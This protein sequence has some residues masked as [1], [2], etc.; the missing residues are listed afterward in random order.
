[1]V[2]DSVLCVFS[3]LCARYWFFGSLVIRWLVTS[4]T[5][6][7][8]LWAVCCQCRSVFSHSVLVVQVIREM[9]RVWK[10]SRDGQRFRAAAQPAITYNCLN[11]V[12]RNYQPLLPGP[13]RHQRYTPRYPPWNRPVLLQ[14]PSLYPSRSMIT[15]V[16]RV[17]RGVLKIRYVLLGGAVGGGVSMQRVS[18]ESFV[19]FV[20]ACQWVLGSWSS[21]GG[22]LVL[23]IDLEVR[24]Y[25]G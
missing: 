15:L 18:L 14:N 6:W 13:H 21:S 20:L 10:H 25:L 4:W 7:R 19:Y 16:G 3:V 9:F 12:K 24:F 1:M 5:R 23:R 2:T 17:L 8:H 22:C 11:V